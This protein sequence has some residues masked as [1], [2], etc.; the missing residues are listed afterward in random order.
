MKAWRKRNNIGSVITTAKVINGHATIGNLFKCAIGMLIV[1]LRCPISGLIS[2][3]L[4]RRAARI[5]QRSVGRV[6]VN[7]LAKVS[8]GTS[9]CYAS[10][11]VYSSLQQSCEHGPQ[12][13]QVRRWD[14]YVRSGQSHNSSG[15]M[16]LHC[17][18]MSP[19]Q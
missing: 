1:K 13:C 10:T 17:E 18:K 9:I 5:S 14:Q 19:R 6:D 2:L 11:R 12:S 7:V 15:R 8:H 3:D 4:A 16:H